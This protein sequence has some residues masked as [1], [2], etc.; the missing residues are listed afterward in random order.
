[1][2]R[3]SVTE[4]LSG[5]TIAVWPQWTVSGMKGS[6]VRVNGLSAPPADSARSIVAN[7]KLMFLVS[8]CDV[9]IKRVYGIV[10]GVLVCDVYYSGRDVAGQLPEYAVEKDSL[11]SAVNG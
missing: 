6:L 8:G 9:F 7:R 11:S 2:Y 10:D 1:M 4:V 3:V 5:N